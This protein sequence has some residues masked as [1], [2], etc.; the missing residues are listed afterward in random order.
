MIK[1]RTYSNKTKVNKK[2][3]IKTKLLQYSSVYLP[4]MH[5][6]HHDEGLSLQHDGNI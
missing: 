3:K 6:L 2:E 1:T 4:P 5:K